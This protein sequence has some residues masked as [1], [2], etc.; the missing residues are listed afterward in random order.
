[1]DKINR[2][3][4]VPEPT[5]SQVPDIIDSLSMVSIDELAKI[6]LYNEIL[7]YVK[8]MADNPDDVTYENLL[9]YIRSIWEKM[10][11]DPY[12]EVFIP[13]LNWSDSSPSDNYN[14]MQVKRSETMS[15]VIEKLFKLQSSIDI[16]HNYISNDANF[17]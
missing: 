14:E 3:V 13:L 11:P 15:L 2:Y 1:M 4:Y 6:E 5:V 8:S 9:D 12:T 7:A 17:Q 10:S 16:I